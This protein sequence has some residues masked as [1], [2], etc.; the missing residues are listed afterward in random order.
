MSAERQSDWIRLFRSRP[1]ASLSCLVLSGIVAL[2][3][4]ADSQLL[5]SYTPTSDGPI[6]IECA[7]VTP[8]AGQ[9]Q[10]L[11]GIL[12]AA[13]GRPRHTWRQV[14]HGSAGKSIDLAGACYRKRDVD[15]AGASLCCE[16][17]DGNSSRK[18]FGARVVP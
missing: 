1:V 6:S 15:A 17:S 11:L 14:V 10:C 7:C 5:Q 18:F 4:R 2:T 9:E 3:S 13:A 8:T 12:D 16:G